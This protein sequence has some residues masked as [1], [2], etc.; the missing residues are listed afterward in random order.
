[1]PATLSVTL[2]TYMSATMCT[3]MS[4][5]MSTTMSATTMSSLR[6]VRSQRRRQNGNPKVFTGKDHLNPLLLSP[7]LDVCSW[8]W[9]LILTGLPLLQWSSLPDVQFTCRR[10]YKQYTCTS[11]RFRIQQTINS[12]DNSIESNADLFG[13]AQNCKSGESKAHLKYCLQVGWADWKKQDKT[14]DLI[15]NTGCKSKEVHFD[16]QHL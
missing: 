15:H 7:R 3:S 16:L 12:V 5:A 13:F 9:F 10:V 4:A 11:S 6:F 8:N 2:S 14:Y 1:M